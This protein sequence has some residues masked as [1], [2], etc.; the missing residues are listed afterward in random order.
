M[1]TPPPTIGRPRRL[2]R[3]EKREHT[4]AA[5]L[6]AAREVFGERGY[7]GATLD[8]IAEAAGLSK[9]AL[10]HYF[11]SKDA[12]FLAL[13]DERCTARAE[14]IREVFSSEGS[15]VDHAEQAAAH[16]V[17]SL[18]QSPEWMRLFF[19]FVAHAARDDEFRPELT[20][21]V[22]EIRAAITDVVDQQARAIGT[23]LPI[24][25]EHLA[26]TINALGNGLA[27]ERL[28]DP[29]A[30]PDD[31]FGTILGLLLLGLAAQNDAGRSAKRP[32]KTRKG[33]RQ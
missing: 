11:D 5:L 15:P 4:R 9:G 23:D 8:D 3:E 12:L 18:K 32:S 16:Y 27:L 6:V 24:P 31:L 33:A 20:A 13:L 2:N 28:A 19:E 25:P 26:I 14:D 1:S 10:Y 21:R 22:R 17:D 29:E 30:V 7:T